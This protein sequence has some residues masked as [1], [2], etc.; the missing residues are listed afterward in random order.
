MSRRSFL[1]AA[2][3]FTQSTGGL[4]APPTTAFYGDNS[5][6][7]ELAEAVDFRSNYTMS[8]WFWLDSQ[9]LAGYEYILF[10]IRA[11]SSNID[12]ISVNGTP[13]VWNLFCQDGGVTAINAT[14]A[15][16]PTRDAWNHIGL[17]K[18]ADTLTL[19]INQTSVASGTVARVAGDPAPTNMR[20]GSWNGETGPM[21]GATFDLK[22]WTAALSVAELT[23]EAAQLLPARAANHWGTYILSSGADLAEKNALRASWTLTGTPSTIACPTLPWTA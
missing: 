16:S 12:D 2:A 19:Y 15:G 11:P 5:V 1:L 21:F 23:S 17:V 8:G 13:F 3:G 7:L 22:F 14:S 9:G 18:S 6:K 4:G 10:N 20:L